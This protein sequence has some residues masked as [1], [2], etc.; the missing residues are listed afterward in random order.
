MSDINLKLDEFGYEL[1]FVGFTE[2]RIVNIITVVLKMK[3][4]A[5]QRF[6]AAWGPEKDPRSSF[7]TPPGSSLLQLSRALPLDQMA[8]ALLLFPFLTHHI[9]DQALLPDHFQNY[10]IFV[11]G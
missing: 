1:S 4:G 11:D 7:S 5:G 9:D 3:H 6:G 2:S 8:A 10:E